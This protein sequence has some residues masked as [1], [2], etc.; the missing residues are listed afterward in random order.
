V[1]F[2]GCWEALV[3]EFEVV[4]KELLMSFEVVFLVIEEFINLDEPTAI[5]RFSFL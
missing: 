4:V 3:D 2:F 1:D 5:L